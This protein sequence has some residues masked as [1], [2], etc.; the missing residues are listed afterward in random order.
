MQLL[1]LPKMIFYI[2]YL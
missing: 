2:V 1:K